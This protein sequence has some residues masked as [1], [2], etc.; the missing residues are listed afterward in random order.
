MDKSQAKPT[1]NPQL[2]NKWTSQACVFET[3]TNTPCL[4]VVLDSDI[5]A[6]EQHT[7]D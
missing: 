1:C 6:E 5:L 4:K 2:I 7:S 3:K